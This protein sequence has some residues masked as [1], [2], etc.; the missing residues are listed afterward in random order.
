[1][2]LLPSLSPQ[3]RQEQEILGNL[4]LSLALLMKLQSSLT[5]QDLRKELVDLFSSLRL[6]WPSRRCLLVLLAN[7]S[8][9]PEWSEMGLA[10]AGTA[11]VCGRARSGGHLVLCPLGSAGATSAGHTELLWHLVTVVGTT[12]RVRNLHSTSFSLPSDPT[13]QNLPGLPK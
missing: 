3:P 2:P 12:R 5:P 11:G 7:S 8:P 1:M 10:G 6:I 9:S 4:L 13:P